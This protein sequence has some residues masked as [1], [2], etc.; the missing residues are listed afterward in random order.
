MISETTMDTNT[1]ST[2][3]RI[4]PRDLIPHHLNRAMPRIRPGMPEWSA[5][6]EDIQERGIQTPIQ[7]VGPNQVVDG[8]TRREVAVAIGVDTVPIVRVPDTEGVTVLVEHLCLQKHLTKG[9]R[10]YVCW[11]LTKGLER[12]KQAR[13]ALSLRKGN[14]PMPIQSASGN[15]GDFGQFCERYGFSRDTFEQA[16]TLHLIFAGDPFT[17]KDRSLV[18]VDHKALRDLW[19][20]KI[21]DLDEPKGLGAVLAGIA[22]AKATEGKERLPNPEVQLERFEEGVQAINSVAKL[23]P[24]I[25]RESRPQIVAAWSKLASGWPLDLRRELADA[26]VRDAEPAGYAASGDS[27][28]E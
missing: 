22:G 20:P 15:I 7:V 2:I 6:F 28:P 18:G 26:L 13:K 19:E 23:W 3:E 21:L 10:A 14:S 5:L 17:L 12:E 9:Q 11:H 16:R 27:S 25:R 8:W 4:D 24:K 1:I